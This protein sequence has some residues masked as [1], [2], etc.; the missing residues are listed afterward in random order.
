MPTAETLENFIEWSYPNDIIDPKENNLFK[1]V[2]HELTCFMSEVKTISKIEL[3]KYLKGLSVNRRESLI[4]LFRIFTAVSRTNYQIFFSTWLIN[5]KK[6]KLIFKQLENKQHVLRLK[7]KNYEITITEKNLAEICMDDDIAIEIIDY[8]DEKKI[9]EVLTLIQSDIELGRDFL[10]TLI[11]YDS[12]G[13]QA[14]NRGKIAER[15]TK[16]CL[17]RFGLD[18]DV[19]YNSTDIDVSDQLIKRLENECVIQKTISKK[20]FED[21]KEL[22][23]KSNFKRKSDIV[24]PLNNPVLFIQS[25]FYASDVASI[26]QA[27]ISE[28]NAEKTL[29]KI[30]QTNTGLS[31]KLIGLID[32]PGWAYSISFSRLK[33]VLDVVDDYFGL[34]TI[35]TKLRKLLHAENVTTP[36]DF[37]IG[38]LL[39][40]NTNANK[41][42]LINKVSQM[43]GITIPKISE[44]LEK[45]LSRKKLSFN[46]GVVNIIDQNRIELAKKYLVLDLIYLNSKSSITGEINSPENISITKVDLKS[47]LDQNYPLTELEIQKYLNE[48]K[49]KLLIVLR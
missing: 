18:E 27:T 41:T 34:R 10:K 45:W 26:A 44:E 15:I 21:V 35:P 6:G 33:A 16:Q 3:K 22:I 46:S 32:G 19:D 48:L 39:L 30:A 42:N 23:Q 1:E 49:L 2:S 38:I 47:I 36:L 25:S 7:I 29:L 43:Y 37:E 31:M 13:S 9:I 5:H 40:N 11:Q 28:L 14:T 20:I 4:R 24:I 8:F 12:K 17:Q